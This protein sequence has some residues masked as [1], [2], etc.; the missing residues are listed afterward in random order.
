M[1]RSG[2]LRQVVRI[3]LATAAATGQVGALSAQQPP[4]STTA[5]APLEEVIVTGTRLPAPNEVSVS[6]ITSVMS[7]DILRT[8]LTRIEDVLDALPMVFPSMNSTNNNGADGTASVNLRG[9]GSQR[10]YG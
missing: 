4:A 6:P 9:L 10:S 2:S 7:V 1:A 5:P 8:G 3:A